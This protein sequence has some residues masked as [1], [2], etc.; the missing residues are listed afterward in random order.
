MK[1]LITIR[2]ILSWVSTIFAQGP[3]ELS[4]K[5]YDAPNFYTGLSVQ[6]TSGGGFIVVG[7]TTCIG[8]VKIERIHSEKEVVGE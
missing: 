8:G 4:T 5:T 3:D 7:E 6:E 2:S 1:R